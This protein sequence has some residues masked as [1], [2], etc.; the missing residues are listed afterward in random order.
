[1]KELLFLNVYTNEMHEYVNQE[2]CSFEFTGVYD[3]KENH[4]V[5]GHITSRGLIYF[6][7]GCWWVSG[8]STHRLHKDY[9]QEYQIKIIRHKSVPIKLKYGAFYKNAW[10]KT[11]RVLD[12]FSTIFFP[13]EQLCEYWCS[14]TNQPII[15]KL[16]Q[17]YTWEEITL[18]EFTESQN[19][20]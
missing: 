3:V 12:P 10:G 18:E 6:E 13:N 17:D 8:N 5:D 11:I 2:P 20:I 4:I 16:E 15:T 14:K 1:M 9:V 7:D 19:R